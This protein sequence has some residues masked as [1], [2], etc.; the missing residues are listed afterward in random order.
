MPSE[1]VA[2]PIVGIGASAGGLEAFRDALRFLPVDTG[3]AY[4]LV[5]HMDPRH[6][7]LLPDLLARATRMEVHEARADM[8]VCANHVYVIAPNTDMT[9]SQGVLQLMPRTEA[10]G[11][12]LSI[13][14]F[15]RS[16]AESRAAGALGVILSGMATDG[17]LG[18]QAIKAEGGMTFAQEPASAQFSEMPNSAITAGCVDFVGS[19]EAI[20]R[21]LTRISR[22]PSLVEVDTPPSEP[23]FATWEPEFQQILRVLRRRTGTDFTAY[24]PATLKR[25]IGRRMI[26]VQ[27]E[28]PA[29]YL[30]YLSDHQSEGN[31][32]YQDMLIGVT[33]FFRDPSTFQ[34][35]GREIWSALIAT[36]A[37]GSPL[38]IWVP[39]CSTGEEVYSLAICLLEFLAEEKQPIPPIQ[40]FGTDL[41]PQA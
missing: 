32:L 1:H 14:T 37:T 5:Q 41:N 17:T 20:A 36:K 24:K 15:L 19:P 29:Q 26:L 8:E 22:H 13:D 6:E 11:Q 10:G 31:A 40:F 3:M 2:F 16:L 4:V 30:A 35:L 34:T 21:E 28:S 38:R 27:S 33:S 12:H 23:E 18:L 9:L 39:G 7:S 25:R